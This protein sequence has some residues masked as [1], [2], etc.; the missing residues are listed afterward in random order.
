MERKSNTKKIDNIPDLRWY[1]FKTAQFIIQ[2]QQKPSPINCVSFEHMKQVCNMWWNF[3]LLC[4]Q[5][6]TSHEL[7]ICF[8]I[9]WSTLLVKEDG[10]NFEFVRFRV[11]SL[12]KEAR[13]ENEL[14]VNLQSLLAKAYRTLV[15]SGQEK[16]IDQK[17]VGLSWCYSVFFN[18]LWFPTVM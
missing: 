4:N 17:Q 11:L 1:R 10:G 13:K 9:T 7:W 16:I 2:G 6:V 18:W 14:S 5:K 3:P 15:F 8:V 12:L